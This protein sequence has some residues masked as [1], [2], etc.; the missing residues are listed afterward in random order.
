MGSQTVSKHGVGMF[1]KLNKMAGGG[2]VNSSSS[3]SDLSDNIAKLI[4]I[5]EEIR[6]RLNPSNNKDNKNP[7]N[8][9]ESST[10]T[11]NINITTNLTQNGTVESSKTDVT[12]GK[13]DTDKE[14]LVRLSK[15][16]EGKVREV[17]TNES[18]PGGILS[19]R[20]VSRK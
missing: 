10:P 11:Y 6:D 5:N 16:I 13:S 14:T 17:V 7:N 18:R 20:F 19:E 15:T 4:S 3:S 9:P 8:K 2:Y 1:D 12:G